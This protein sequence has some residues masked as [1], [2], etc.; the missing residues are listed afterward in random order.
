MFNYSDS[1][2]TH[3]YMRTVVDDRNSPLYTSYNKP[4]SVETWENILGKATNSS[5]TT[6][7]HP[8]TKGFQSPNQ[9]LHIRYGQGTN[10]VVN[11]Y[12][13]TPGD[14]EPWNM[15]S[16]AIVPLP[17]IPA[18][19]NWISTTAVDTGNVSDAG[20]YLLVG[21]SGVSNATHVGLST[22]GSPKILWAVRAQD[23][24]DQWTE[25]ETLF[26]QFAQGSGAYAMIKYFTNGPT[27]ASK[28]EL[29]SYANGAASPPTLVP[30]TWNVGKI[31]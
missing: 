10:L 5:A 25:G 29:W 23:G 3:L 16:Q 28:L 15:L 19:T 14:N 2:S 21:R 11:T 8:Y 1:D 4:I 13:G 24:N 31:K 17:K 30:R 27:S 22:N 18:T 7:L 9:I 12:G 20:V 6:Y 26:G